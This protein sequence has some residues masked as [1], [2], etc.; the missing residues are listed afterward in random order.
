MPHTPAAPQNRRRFLINAATGGLG[1]LHAPAIAQAASP[2]VNPF[3]LGVASGDPT[4][5]GVVLWTRLAPEP[6][7]GG[8]MPAHPVL[9]RWQ[10]AHDEHMQHVVRHGVAVAWPSLAHAVHVEVDGLAPGRWYYYRFLA[11][12]HASPVGR[13]RTLPRRG[14]PV[15][16]FRFAFVSCQDWQN[17]FYS[18]YRNLAREDLDLVVHLGDYIYE[19]GADPAGPRQHQ[20]AEAVTLEDYRNRFAQYRTDPHLQAAHAAFPWLVV[21]D[22]HDVDNNYADGI[23]EDGGDRQ[24][25][26]ARRANAYRA[27][28]E[29]MPLRRRSLP[30]GA[31]ARIYRGMTVGDLVQFSALDTRQYRSDQPCGDNLQVPCA[32]AFD[33]SQTMTGPDQERWL[34]SR[35]AVSPARW[36]VIAQQTMFAQY[37][38]FA[39]PGILF[40]M[41]QW[42]GYQAARQRITAFLQ[43]ASPSNPIVLTGDIH[44]SWVHNLKA[45]Y[46]HPSSAVV[47]TEFVGTS[48]TSDFPVLAVGPVLAAMADNPHTLFFDGLFR[49]YVR[50][51]VDRSLWRTE[52]RAVPTILAADVEAFTLASFV[53]QDGHAGALPG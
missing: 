52:F 3:A 34:L 27:Y 4:S 32:A 23:P 48:V 16:G 11:R 26:L 18:A 9:V 40:N 37:D 7:A 29:H 19:D 14:G 50:C 35:L 49:G 24:A 25:F 47:G 28:Y 17:G 2:G 8:G 36:N 31:D 15:A 13:T 5:D 45:N 22:D 53:V 10:V 43:W 44:S 51:S 30:T 42:D 12:G 38:F 6:L 21:P 1:I 46:F 41:D 20:G 33:L 39:G